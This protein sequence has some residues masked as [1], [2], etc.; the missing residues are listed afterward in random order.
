MNNPF[1]KKNGPFN[2]ANVLKLSNINNLENY[3]ETIVNDIKDL[4]T[5]EKNNITFFHS[6]KYENLA[7]K[8]NAQFCITTRKLSQFLPKNCNPIV[9]DNVLLAT[10][11][12]TKIFYPDAVNDDFD[13]TVESAEKISFINKIKYGKNILIGR[14]VQ[15]GSNCSIGHNSIIENNVIIGDNCSIGS[16][17][18]LRKT[19]I[20]NNVNILD[21]CVIGKKGFGFYPDKKKIIDIRILGLLSSK[22][23]VKLV[24]DAP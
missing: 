14:D 12:I 3:S 15:I 8:T 24:V 23:I 10:A 17:V 20:K 2:I 5:A 19:I 13:D 9:V 6:K 7:S 21:G 11:N 16:N 18:I 1:F 4:V 22:I